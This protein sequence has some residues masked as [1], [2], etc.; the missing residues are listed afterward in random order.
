MRRK[1][2]WA[3][4]LAS[5]ARVAVIVLVGDLV[6][7]PATAAETPVITSIAVETGRPNLVFA[8]FPATVEYQIDRSLSPA[9]PFVP[10]P[11]G[12]FQGFTW[13]GAAGPQAAGFFRLTP[14][15][16]APDQLLAA[17]LLSRLAYGPTADDR[18]RLAAMGPAAFLAEQLAP[19]SIPEDLDHA[20]FTPTWR[21][22]VATGVGSASTLFLYL[23]VAG[24]AFVDDLRLVEGVGDDG[25]RPNLLRDGDFEAALGTDWL[26]SPNLLGSALTPDFQHGG[27][28]ALHVVASDAGTTQGSSIYQLITPALSKDRTYTLTYW[29]LTSATETAR[30]TVRLS[31][32][33]IVSAVPLKE[34]NSSPA[35]IFE[36]LTAGTAT[37]NDLRAWHV[38]HA[39]QSRK[40]LTEV[41][42]QFCEN[43]FVTEYSKVRDYFD[44][45]GLDPDFAG[46]IATQLEFAE[47]LRWRT[48]LQ[49][50]A[51]TFLDLLRISAESPAMIIY[52]D[53]V[54]SRGNGSNIANENYARELCEL[55]SHG[56]DNGY[57]QADIVQISRV[58]TGWSIRLVATD[59]ITNPF[60]AVSTNYLDPNAVTNKTAVTNLIGTWAFNYKSAGHNT[61]QK[62]LFFQH[63]ATTGAVTTPKLVPDRFGPPWAGR[64]YSLVIP[65]GSGTNSIQE[66]YTLLAHMANQPFTEEFI[67][68]KLC[69]LFVHDDFALGYDF[70]DAE[71]TPEESLVHA[72][73]LAWENPPSGGPRGQLR[74]VLRVI[75]NSDLF[76]LNSGSLQKIK[77]P[78]EFNVS[79]LRA[80]RA[81]NE[82][83]SYTA[84]TDGYGLLA[85]MG[86][87]GRMLLFDRME[88]N[89]YPEDGPA[90]ISA[91][92][93]AERLRFVQAALMPAGMTGKSDGGT[94]TAI[95]PVA[96]L[97][98][99]APNSLGDAGAVADYFLSLLFPAEGQANLATY[100][101]IAVNFL[102]TDDDG[103]AASLAGLTPGSSAYDLRVRGAV[104]ML[105]TTQRFQ[106]Q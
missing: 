23:D 61:A 21:K 34:P 84:T 25:T 68:V 13:N 18:A 105:L 9:G 77:T 63:D 56:V 94:A 59:E 86:R 82:D 78:L 54:G 40:Q 66:G 45:A 80:L 89:G 30:L 17:T 38:L 53:T 24:E 41:L 58:W 99:K 74:D 55:F 4:W 3:H 91:G 42:R 97:R 90:W 6:G 19:E 67:S 79:V 96:L 92:T 29:Y 36:R 95:D 20:E 104:A 73:M 75:F 15:T 102:N 87:M 51:A 7:R 106:E 46:R 22:V 26:L 31:G 35:P 8:P 69:R 5:S 98:L 70:T 10:D 12:Q 47:N 49:Q 28:L 2:K 48:A 52:L 50:P 1:S 100:K 76:R 93:L 103:R 60:A 27:S 62:K 88:P 11:A 33:G 57:D 65:A 16:L 39:V 44:N 71:T 83:G 37:I 32:S 85:P 81:R 64:D 14:R 72:C 101:A 43:H